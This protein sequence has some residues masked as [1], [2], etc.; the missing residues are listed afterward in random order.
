[1]LNVLLIDSYNSMLHE[2]ALVAN[3]V[4]LNKAAKS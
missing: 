4:P 1:M 2:F 3:T